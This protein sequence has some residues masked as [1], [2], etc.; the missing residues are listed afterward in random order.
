[1]GWNFKYSYK[2]VPF[3]L[4]YSTKQT[5]EYKIHKKGQQWAHHKSTKH[6]CWRLFFAFNLNERAKL[7]KIGG[8][9]SNDRSRLNYTKGN[10]IRMS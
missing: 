9:F 7:T 6:I 5:R 2:G 10:R 4:H 3:E 1:M 8:K